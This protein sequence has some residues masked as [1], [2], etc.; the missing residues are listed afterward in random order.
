M[1]NIKKGFT[2][3]ELLVVVL[4]IAILGAIALPQ[5]Q[6]AVERTR[7]TSNVEI[8]KAIH[9]AVIQYYGTKGEFPSSFSKLWVTLPQGLYTVSGKTM[10]KDDNTCVIILQDSNT[11]PALDMSCKTSGGTISDWV[12]SYQFHVMTSDEG[13]GLFPGD[14]LFKIQASDQHRTDVLRRAAISSGWQDLGGG[15]FKMP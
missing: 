5:Y 7:I 11:P 15:I 1:K 2:L 12:M 9:D 8:M 10:T 6:V 14:R 4:I 13:G 3:I